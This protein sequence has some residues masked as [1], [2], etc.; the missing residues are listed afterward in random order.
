MKFPKT[1]FT[2]DVSVE[3]KGA[4][5]KQVTIN[6]AEGDIDD[7]VVIASSIGGNS[8]RVRVQGQIRRDGFPEGMKIDMTPAQWFGAVRTITKR[9]L[10]SDEIRALALKTASE[11][12]DERAKLIAELQAMG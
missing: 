8:P 7:A 3:P 4:N 11:N 12:A 2:I 9:E 10:T 1:S 5:P 6:I